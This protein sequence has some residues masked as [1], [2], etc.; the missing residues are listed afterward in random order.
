MKLCSRLSPFSLVFICGAA[1]LLQ[2]C[3]GNSSDNAALAGG[4][5]GAA[6]GAGTGAL[7]GSAMTNGSVGESALVG[8]AIG[9]PVGIVAGIAIHQLGQ[10]DERE[11][12]DTAVENNSN[13]IVANQDDIEEIRKEIT[14]EEAAIKVDDSRAGYAYDGPTIGNPRR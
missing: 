13:R 11:L 9:I 10:Q 2:A 5:S 7:I 3:S 4:V 6:I 12:L 14:E 8:G 1:A